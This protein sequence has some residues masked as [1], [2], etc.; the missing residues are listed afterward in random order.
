MQDVKVTDLRNNLPAYLAVVQGGEELRI[1]SRGKVIARIVPEKTEVDAARQRLLALR[2]NIQVGDVLS[3][4][5]VEW[6][7]QQ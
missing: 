2:G 4:I 1:L 6:D 5:D 3:P 7:A